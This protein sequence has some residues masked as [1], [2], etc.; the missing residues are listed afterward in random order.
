MNRLKLFVLVTVFTMCL[1]FQSMAVY[2]YTETFSTGLN[3]WIPSSIHHNVTHELAG[4]NGGGYAQAITGNSFGGIQNLESDAFTGDATGV[5]SFH[6]DI[7]LFSGTLTSVYFRF[8]EGADA[9]GWR[10]FLPVNAIGDS[11][12][13]FSVTFDPTWSD[14]DAIANGWSQEPSTA[15]WAE[16]MSDLHSVNIRAFGA[17]GSVIGYDNV[18]FVPEPTTAVFGAVRLGGVMMRRRRG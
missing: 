5:S 15:S 12:N 3:L 13:T 2:R 17:D 8:R 4:G 18:G 10:Y 6:A 11:W 16:V 14:G 7:R 9:N 1:S